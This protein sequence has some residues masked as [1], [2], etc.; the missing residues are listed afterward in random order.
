MPPSLGKIFWLNLVPPE[1]SP[2]IALLEWCP[3]R[4]NMVHQKGKFNESTK[5]ETYVNLGSS[6]G[7]CLRREFWVRN[8]SGSWV[9]SVSE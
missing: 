7:G 3:G 4:T 1:V 6:A 9:S 8:S 5:G 2:D